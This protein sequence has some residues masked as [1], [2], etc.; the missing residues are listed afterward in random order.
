MESYCIEQTKSAR[1][2]QKTSVIAGAKAHR[3]PSDDIS[4]SCHTGQT[5]NGS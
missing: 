1:L 4:R 5:E 2:F 3:T